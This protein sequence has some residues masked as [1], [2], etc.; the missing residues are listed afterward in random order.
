MQDS[1]NL[2]KRLNSN[3]NSE[4][5]FVPEQEGAEAIIGYLH[6]FGLTTKEAKIYFALSKLGSAT[7]TEIAGT[8]KFSR[9]QTYRAIKGLLDNGIVEMSLERP[10]KYTPL[11]IE[12]ALNLLGQEAER[13]ILELEKKTPLLLKQWTALSDPQ[14]D[15]TNYTFRFIQGPK[16]VS[17]FRIM[18]YESAKKGITTIM[19]PNDLMKCVVDGADD[20][21]EKLTYNN[22]SVKGLSEVNKL[23]LDASKRFLEFSKLNHTT[24]SN[25]LPFAVIDEQEALICLSRDGK[26]GVPESAIWTNH[27]ELVGFLKEVFEMLWSASIDGSSRIREIE[28]IKYPS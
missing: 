11:K 23:N 20:V 7:A 17:K 25:V 24:H 8:T 3:G 13:K 10:R 19:K 26:D 14:V 6:D 27:P 12:Q 16:N 18:L 22:V 4:E 28:S 1:L 21:F 5:A 2:G 9:L 15:K